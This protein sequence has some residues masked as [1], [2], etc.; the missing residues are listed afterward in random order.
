MPLNEL[1]DEC[2]DSLEVK[3]ED[4]L[5]N[6]YDMTGKKKIIVEKKGEEERVLLLTYY[7]TMCCYQHLLTY[8]YQLINVIT[9]H[10][11]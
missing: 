5:E 8:F 10:L 9:L 7:Q 1:I 3:K 2:S 11:P 6:V 4:I